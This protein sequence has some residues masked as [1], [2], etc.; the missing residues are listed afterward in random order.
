MKIKISGVLSA[1]TAEV[2]AGSEIQLKAV[3]TSNNIIINAESSYFVGQDGKYEFNVY[4]GRYDVYIQFSAEA[5][6]KVGRIGVY[7]DS[8]PGTLEEYLLIDNGGYFKPEALIQFEKDC[9]AAAASAAAAKSSEDASAGSA[10]AAAASAA[11]ARSAEDASADNASAAAGSAAAAKLSEDVSAGSASAAAGSAAAAK[12]SEDASAGSASAAAGSAVAAKLSED[13]SADNAS[14]AAGSAVAAKLS[15]D[16]SASSASAAAGSAAAAK[17]SED[18]SASSASAAAGSAA[19]AK[20]SEDASASSASAAAGSAVAA[21]LSEDASAGS[22]SAAAGSA[23]AAESAAERAES[24]G[25]VDISTLAKLAESNTFTAGNTFYGATTFNKE[26]VKVN[27]NFIS[28]KHTSLDGGL[29]IGRSTSNMQVSCYAEVHLHNGHRLS[30]HSPGAAIGAI[31]FY[32]GS[33]SSARGRICVSYSKTFTLMHQDDTK[34]LL[35]FASAEADGLKFRGKDRVEQTIYHSGYLPPA[36]VVAGE[37]PAEVTQPVFYFDDAA[38]QL[39]FL[40]GDKKY[41]VTLTP[42]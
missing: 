35:D 39:C 17:L 2:C 10:S 34:F 26:P 22:A 24:A 36:A 42:A 12:L 18:A 32:E 33:Y 31:D 29:E 5:P 41:T 21:K 23:A 1:P 30:I 13:A 6:Q 8:A 3:T 38:E 11:A 14:A 28:T 27:Y 40:C 9:A 25:G 15:E 4:P 20:L 19:A 16:A 37:L 7:E